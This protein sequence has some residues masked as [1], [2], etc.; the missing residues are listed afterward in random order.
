MQKFKLLQQRIDERLELTKEKLS[1]EILFKEYN[2]NAQEK[3]IFIA[4]LREEYLGKESE[5]ES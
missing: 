4:L 5:G 1:L 3:I 2:L